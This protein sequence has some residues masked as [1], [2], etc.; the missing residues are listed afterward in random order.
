M[1][2]EFLY[3]RFQSVNINQD[4][5][6]LKIEDRRL[7]KHL[8]FFTI[9]FCITFIAGRIIYEYLSTF[10]SDLTI[11]AVFAVA[12][13]IVCA[14]RFSLISHRR[15]YSFD[16]KQG[17]YRLIELFPFKTVENTGKIEDITRVQMDVYHHDT[18]RT[19]SDYYT[20]QTSIIVDG[21]GIITVDEES[22][23]EIASTE[24]GTAIS[25]FLN[26]PFD[27]NKNY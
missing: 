2:G 13:L 1:F 15:L 6:V 25:D 8:W 17:T 10:W 7:L 3:S 27:V 12:V 14:A 5:N 21:S 9:V 4:Q 20:Y 24:I 16:K 26:I 11:F 19:N 22:K 18:N 23:N